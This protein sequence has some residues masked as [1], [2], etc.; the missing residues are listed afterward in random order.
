[1]KFQSQLIGNTLR[2]LII[3]N[4]FT[5]LYIIFISTYGGNTLIPAFGSYDPL[6][7]P[8][9]MSMVH[10]LATL[11]SLTTA[12]SVFQNNY[13]WCLAWIGYCLSISLIAWSAIK[14][15]KAALCIF[16]ILF[17]ELTIS[18]SI[19][20]GELDV[21][22]TNN[23]FSVMFIALIFIILRLNLTSRFTTYCHKLSLH[24]IK[25]AAVLLA[26]AA[27]LVIFFYLEP[28]IASRHG[29]DYTSV[30][31]IFYIL[32]GIFLLIP[33][34]LLIWHKILRRNTCESLLDV[35]IVML[36][37]IV[38]AGGLA[39]F[40]IEAEIFLKY[41]LAFSSVVILSPFVFVAINF[42]I[43]YYFKKTGLLASVKNIVSVVRYEKW[44]LLLILGFALI[45]TWHYYLTSG[46][47]SLPWFDIWEFW[48]IG[49]VGASG[50]VLNLRY[51]YF[52][53]GQSSLFDSS[54]L[55]SV[56][57]IYPDKYITLAFMK[58]IPLLVIYLQAV[59]IYAISKQLM[60]RSRIG[61]SIK[62]NAISVLAALVFLSSAWTM[63]YSAIFARESIG[64]LLVLG[65]FGAIILFE[66]TRHL[67]FLFLSIALSVF[68]IYASP[69]QILVIIPTF[70][71][72]FVFL[73]RDRQIR[74]KRV[75]VLIFCVIVFIISIFPFI[76]SETMIWWRLENGMIGEPVPG[77][78]SSFG[79]TAS[80]GLS[81]AVAPFIPIF[82]PN[83]TMHLITLLIVT[84]LGA[85]GFF[86]SLLGFL[87]AKKHFNDLK[88]IWI[89]LSVYV[90]LLILFPLWGP[91]FSPI[92]GD[93]R[94]FVFSI[95][96]IL[97]F[98]FAIGINTIIGLKI[99]RENSKL[100]KSFL[101]I[102][103]IFLLLFGVL[104]SPKIDLTSPTSSTEFLLEL[105]KELPTNVMVVVDSPFMSQA[106]LLSPRYTIDPGDFARYFN[107]IS[108][109]SSLLNLLVSYVC[110]NRIVII[111]MGGVVSP[112]S[113]IFNTILN[114]KSPLI[115][116][117]LYQM[118]FDIVTTNWCPV[119]LITPSNL[120]LQ[121]SSQSLN[122]ENFENQRKE[123]ISG[124][125]S[126]EYWSSSFGEP[127][128]DLNDTVEGLPS[129][130]A[131]GSR[132]FAL[133]YIPESPINMSEFDYLD[134][135]A[136]SNESHQDFQVYLED[137]KNEVWYN[138]EFQNSSTWEE[139]LL[140]LHNPDGST[141]LVD[142]GNITQ[143]E[144][145]V[146]NVK[147]EATIAVAD[148]ELCY[149][150]WEIYGNSPQ[151]EFNN[152]VGI[153]SVETSGK[154][155]WWIVD[156]PCNITGQEYGFLVVSAK[157]SNS[158]IPVYIE[159]RDDTD[160]IYQALYL[161][162]LGISNATFSTF[163][164]QIPPNMNVTEVRV[165]FHSL[166]TTP[167]GAY[168]LYVNSMILVR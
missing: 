147:S 91:M 66:R 44:P 107:G 10:V 64:I 22:L 50:S 143:V 3:L 118:V 9:R 11:T 78:A 54:L 27:L 57:S 137:S 69:A 97:S 86:I 92:I 17:L 8:A 63:F 4:V 160:R 156:K 38:S 1:L 161:N 37:G 40:F 125:E 90:A 109:N 150:G 49:Y 21:R 68:T 79:S 93:L 13:I 112:L 46:S 85:V 166:D 2:T 60:S 146:Q 101:M 72:V 163:V 151:L 148:L 26:V 82:S 131:S 157:I 158:S 80:E 105:D 99:M 61:A 32:W 134:F 16:V 39:W 128:I 52:F 45:L 77:L 5:L 121:P 74:A 103:I 83:I 122:L 115:S 152:G 58:Y 51:S 132:D 154:D 59:G 62:E 96:V 42:A 23:F 140:P 6:L 7:L 87:Y 28:A 98:F 18:Q 15:S 88:L 167:S 138:L 30:A 100:Q 55:A 144:F 48:G 159:M 149:F 145:W 142:L 19:V 120:A 34:G 84:S 106:L 130:N 104:I 113:E 20:A 111:K 164:L 127:K 70:T 116:I 108:N 56:F 36:L 119:Y 76:L 102:V 14:S 29:L 47:Y 133:N 31:F 110:A 162:Q 153:F 12:A 135:Y 168:Y 35:F 89:L 24:I 75:K 141:G 81:N 71:A 65:V 25:T 114:A 94:R 117:T 95:T 124:T 126:L 41:Y 123:E 139:F 73:I 43:L 53:P 136:K 67:G 155:Q 129:I 33:I 165:G